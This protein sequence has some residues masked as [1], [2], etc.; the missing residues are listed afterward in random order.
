MKS[1]YLSKFH[2]LTIRQADIHLE[3]PFFLQMK[4]LKMRVYTVCPKSL[5]L[6]VACPYSAMLRGEEMIIW[7]NCRDK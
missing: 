3:D 4:K 5:S 2:Q 7:E 1:L 6:P